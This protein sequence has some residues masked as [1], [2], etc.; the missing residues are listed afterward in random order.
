MFVTVKAK[1][2][3]WPHWTDEQRTSEDLS[4]TLQ[5]IVKSE[6]D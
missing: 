5:H 6:A 2:V 3:Y 1:E 4:K